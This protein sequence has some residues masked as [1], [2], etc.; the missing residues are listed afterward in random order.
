M[1]NF[2]Q[3]LYSI[4][5]SHLAEY[6]LDA[7]LANGVAKNVISEVIDR[8]G[9]QMVYMKNNTRERRTEKHQQIVTE[10]NGVNRV[11]VCRKY[12]ITSVWLK[13]LLKRA[14][15]ENEHAD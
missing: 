1:N 4:I 2:Y 14:E 9:G 15:V 3:N 13:K 6:S 5:K 12:G 10:Y 7:E 8:Y 11:Y